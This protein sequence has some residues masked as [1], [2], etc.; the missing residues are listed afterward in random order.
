MKRKKR[1]HKRI[2]LLWWKGKE[3]NV[4]GQLALKWKILDSKMLLLNPMAK[5]FTWCFF[6][7]I[8]K[9]ITLLSR[10]FPRV[11]C[12]FII[13][14]KIK[15]NKCNAYSSLKVVKYK[16]STKRKENKNTTN[17][18]IHK[19]LVKIWDTVFYL[20]LFGSRGR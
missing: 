18:V 9:V 2:R 5:S 12:R 15:A 13:F 4:E 7:N 16:K 11:F 6:D 17:R 10:L 1:S 20:L 3:Q 14:L 8:S 19:T